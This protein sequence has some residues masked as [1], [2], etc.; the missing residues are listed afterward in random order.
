MK[1]GQTVLI[2]IYDLVLSCVL[3]GLAISTSLSH[4]PYRAMVALCAAFGIVLWTISIVLL[5]AFVI[6][7]RSEV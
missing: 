6:D 2:G 3:F 4:H 5:I 1:P 7:T